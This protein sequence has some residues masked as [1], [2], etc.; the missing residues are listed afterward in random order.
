MGCHTV[1]ISMKAVIRYGLASSDATFI[2]RLTL[3]AA[4]ASTALT[5]SGV[6]PA[7]SIALTSMCAASQGKSS[8]RCPLRTLTTPAGKS[9]VAKTSASVSAG[10][11]GDSGA[12]ATTTLPPQ[13]A[14][15][16]R[17]TSPASA[18][19]SGATIPTTPVGS[20]RVK[21]KYGPATG[22]TVPATCGS[23]SVQPAYQT[24]VST[25]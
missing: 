20:G 19:S 11:G 24:S 22:F 12:G 3:S 7:T 14:G 23:L 13:R 25:A 10:S 17:R 1:F 18:G 2:T 8:P 16:R 15:A 9:L 21:L 6:H 5:S 4:A